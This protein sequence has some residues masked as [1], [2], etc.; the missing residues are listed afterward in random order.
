MCSSD[1]GHA[2][3]GNRRGRVIRTGA[4][5]ARGL[6]DMLAALGPFFASHFHPPGAPPAP[7]WRPL[8]E[9][10]DQPELLLARIGS[11]RAALAGR[12]GCSPDHV[13]L[14]VAASITHLGLTA[15]LMAPA[16]AAGAGQHRL[17]LPLDELWWQ[18]E[19]GGPVPLS[20]PGP[21]DPRAHRGLPERAGPYRLL[22]DVIAPITAATSGLVAVSDR[23]LWGNLASAING[24][25]SQV[26]AQL[27]ALT[28]PALA[29]AASLA[30][31]P[32]LAGERHPSGP[33][34][35]RSSCCLLYRLTPGRPRPVCGDCILAA[36]SP[37][38]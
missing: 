33:Q 16:V 23:V 34:F 3:P 7:P 27:P 12:A 2:K 6:P 25:A 29:V 20:I 32:G 35:R 38:P 36:A 21:P 8:R 4:K 10:T 14:R 22:D 31:H 30:G 26:A 18:D 13:E 17:D 5:W 11:V 28:R 37:V 15:R 1:L 9:L 19:I 24:A